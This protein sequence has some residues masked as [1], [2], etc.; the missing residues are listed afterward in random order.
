[1]SRASSM[2]Y[3]DEAAVMPDPSRRAF[4]ACVHQRRPLSSHTTDASA[5]ASVKPAASPVSKPLADPPVLHPQPPPTSSFSL[6]CKAFLDVLNLSHQRP[7]LLAFLVGG[8]WRRASPP[9][10]AAVRS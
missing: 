10:S 8:R 4:V 3:E 9:P 5:S 2:L 7:S 1:M 6:D